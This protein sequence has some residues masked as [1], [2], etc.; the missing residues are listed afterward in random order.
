MKHFISTI[1]V[2]GVFGLAALPAQAV[3]G[4]S[5][6]LGTG[7][8]TDM[9]R[10]GVQ[11]DWNKRWLQTGEW[12]VGG[13]WEA[14][15]GRWHRDTNAVGQNS[16]LTDVGFTPVFRFQ[17]NDLKGP[18]AEAAVGFHWLS[19]TQIGDKR[20]STQFQFGDHLGAGYRFGDKGQYDLGFRYQ[21]L[22]NGGI[23]RPN[24]GINFSQVRLQ[25]HF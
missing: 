14:S 12:H 19:R 4:V 17:R 23:K 21:H 20:M 10:V 24:N 15:I 9:G 16:N 22:S 18:Y 6:E 7:D 25:Y 3:N 8:S 11:W 2:G 13:Y 5:I 1:F